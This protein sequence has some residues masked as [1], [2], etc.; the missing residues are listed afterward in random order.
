MPSSEAEVIPDI[1]EKRKLKELY[2]S[3][4]PFL[5]EINDVLHRKLKA[6]LVELGVHAT[7]KT[8]VKSF[9]GYYRKLLSRLGAIVAAGSSEAREEAE[10]VA[11]AGAPAAAILFSGARA[12]DGMAPSDGAT[13]S[14]EHLL[15]GSHLTDIIGIRIV[16]PFLDD[17]QVACSLV[18]RDFEVLEIEEKGARRSFREFGYQAT[19]YLIRVPEEEVPRGLTAFH[20]FMEVSDFLAGD[21]PMPFLDLGRGPILC[22]V[23][24]CTLL[25][26]AWAEVEH[27]LIYKSEFSPLDEPL[28]RKL[29]ALNANL[30]LSD[31]IFQE[32]REYQRELHGE[33]F[34]RRQ[35]FLAKALG[36]EAVPA[37]ASGPNGRAGARAVAA[38]RGPKQVDP[39]ASIDELLLEALTAHNGGLYEEAIAIYSA[40]LDTE[41]QGSLAVI[42]LIHR[43]MAHFASSAYERALADFTRANEIDPTN[44]RSFYY[45]ASVHRVLGDLERA[46]ADLDQSLN[47]N[48]FDFEAHYARSQIER[49]LGDFGRA[50][51]DCDA[52]LRIDPDSEEAAAFRS[53]LMKRMGL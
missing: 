6:D 52:A 37:P 1:P 42:L 11:S 47:L 12:G 10:K 35:S 17:I 27:A 53:L 43:G 18:H 23:Q 46:L 33:L 29:A 39:S 2:E 49:E 25:Q 28:K 45:R 20:C 38:A 31:I 40:V 22:E 30:T 48:P 3:Q 19:H 50:L 26:D 32:I 13:P 7:V 21:N 51:S 4:V 16:C 14:I 24:I 9:E 8:R 34:K 44:T 36:P 5:E 41:P 15:G